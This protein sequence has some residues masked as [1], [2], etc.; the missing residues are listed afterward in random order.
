MAKHLSIITANGVI[1]PFLVLKVK[2]GSAIICISISQYNITTRINYYLTLT[3]FFNSASKYNSL[4]SIL[5]IN[6]EW[7]EW[8]IRECSRTCGTGTRSKARTKLVEESNG[9][10]CNGPSSTFEV[11]NTQEC[12]TCPNCPGTAFY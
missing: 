7:G 11:C 1:A 10:T 2:I 6:C 5:V 12:P 4:T 9:G 3:S 8:V